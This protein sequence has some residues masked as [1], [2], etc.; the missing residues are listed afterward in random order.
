LLLRS[1]TKFQTVPLPNG[2]NITDIEFIKNN[3]TR[4]I[5]EGDKFEHYFLHYG[6][7]KQVR[8]LSMQKTPDITNNYSDNKYTIT[9]N[10]KYY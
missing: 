7:D 9:A 10:C 6:T 8:I 5:K 1:S 2:V 4:I 3:M